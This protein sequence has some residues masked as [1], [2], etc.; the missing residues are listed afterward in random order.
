MDALWIPVAKYFFAAVI[1]YSATC[2]AIAA[3][4]FL[5]V[6]K[7][8]REFPPHLHVDDKILYPEG[9]A[10]PNVRSMGGLSSKKAD[11]AD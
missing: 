4:R 10:P 11:G 6:S 9:F 1:S 3:N 5:R 2:F 8:F 7:I